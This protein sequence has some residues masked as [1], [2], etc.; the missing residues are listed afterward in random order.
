ML[1]TCTKVDLAIPQ[2]ENTLSDFKLFKSTKSC[3][4]II[5]ILPKV[6]VFIM[7]ID[8]FQNNVCYIA[9]HCIAG[10]GEGGLTALVSSV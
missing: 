6:I 4:R 5:L 10:A 7:Q 2:C 8:V 3:H 9:H 1:R